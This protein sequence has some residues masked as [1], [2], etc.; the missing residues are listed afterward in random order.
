MRSGASIV[1]EP[2]IQPA[3][4]EALLEAL[5]DDVGSGEVDR[6]LA[7]YESDLVRQ[8]G[9]L[10]VHRSASEQQGVHRI[11]HAM[12]GTSGA[13]GTIALA[14]LCRGLMRQY[15]VARRP[16]LPRWKPS[17]SRRWPPSG[18]DAMPCSGPCDRPGAGFTRQVLRRPSAGVGEAGI[19][20]LL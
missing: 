2:S 11:L 5:E 10:S 17:R 6:L 8:L 4:D 9:S 12:A 14:G 16:H 1:R 7:L 3:F 13:I 20:A 15:P 18:I 19:Y